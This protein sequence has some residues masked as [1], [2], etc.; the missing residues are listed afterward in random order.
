MTFLRE[1]GKTGAKIP[2]IGLGCMGMSE[3]YGSADDFTQRHL[4]KYMESQIRYLENLQKRTQ[5][6]KEIFYQI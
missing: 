6:H 4:R 3:F 5:Y 1:L 2:A